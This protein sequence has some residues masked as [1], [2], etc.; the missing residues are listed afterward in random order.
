MAGVEGLLENLRLSEAERKSVC[1]NLES[2]EKKDDDQVQAVGKLLSEKWTRPK[3]IEQAVGWIWCPVKGIECKD[4]GENIFLFSFNQAS[5]KRKALN[6]GP[7]M[8][9]KRAFGGC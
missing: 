8:L 2:A 1:I 9:F 7:W 6:E 5:G 4:L 3:I